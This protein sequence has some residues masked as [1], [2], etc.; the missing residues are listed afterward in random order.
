M[1]QSIGPIG[2]MVADTQQ[3]GDLISLLLLEEKNLV[4]NG[5][6]LRFYKWIYKEDT[7]RCVG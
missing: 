5:D 4:K 1:N 6:N 2:E 3:H 7:F